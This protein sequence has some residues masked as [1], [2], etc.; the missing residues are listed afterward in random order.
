MAEALGLAASI[1]S[2]VSLLQDTVKA[3]HKLGQL[4]AQFQEANTE[5]LALRSELCDLTQTLGLVHILL[6]RLQNETSVNGIIKKEIQ[7]TTSEICKDVEEVK[8]V[9][10]DFQPKLDMHKNHKGRLKWMLKKGDIGSAMNR[11]IRR[12]Q[13]LHV[14]LSILH[15]NL[16]EAGTSG[17]QSWD[18]KFHLLNSRMKEMSEQV[19]MS[20][21]DSAA[22]VQHKIETSFADVEETIKVEVHRAAV[23][24]QEFCLPQ[25]QLESLALLVTDSL[26][27]D[28]P[29]LSQS[30]KQGYMHPL[31]EIPEQM[32]P[33]SSNDSSYEMRERRPNS[34]SVSSDKDYCSVFSRVLRHTS[35]KTFACIF[36]HLE[37]RRYTS[38]NLLLDSMGDDRTS[39]EVFKTEIGFHFAP[40]LRHFIKHSAIGGAVKFSAGEIALNIFVPRIVDSGDTIQ[41]PIWRAVQ[42]GHIATIKSALTQK[43]VQ[44]TDVTLGGQSLLATAANWGQI[45]VCKL[46]LQQGAATGINMVD[47]YHQ[48]APIHN[49]AE[50]LNNRAGRDIVRLFLTAGADPTLKSGLGHDAATWNLQ[51]SPCVSSIHPNDETIIR[52]LIRSDPSFDLHQRDE[53]GRTL[54]MQARGPPLCVY[55]DLL[56]LGVDATVTDNEGNNALHCYFSSFYDIFDHICHPLMLQGPDILTSLIQKGANPEQRNDTGQL[57]CEVYDE[58]AYER[59][60]PVSSIRLQLQAVIWSEALSRCGIEN[61]PHLFFLLP[62]QQSPL[63]LYLS[64]RPSIESQCRCPL[65]L[66]VHTVHSPPLNPFRFEDR[67][68]AVAKSWNPYSMELCPRRSDWLG[69]EDATEFVAL[70][71]RLLI[72][73]LEFRRA[74]N[75][76]YWNDGQSTN[77]YDVLA[78]SDIE[79]IRSEAASE[80]EW[81][82]AGEE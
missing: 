58:T 34:E 38:Q 57:P 78:E 24:S 52:L 16:L 53:E 23:S 14:K 45:E 11:I 21:R 63:D 32:E 77:L 4:I 60:H 15:T 18:D 75:G 71:I 27:R 80:E 8:D 64:D 73:E 68:I 3:C 56:K 25:S 40:W 13:A 2:M 61:T 26:L 10:E 46:L 33:V 55:D 79:Q 51:T 6:E 59:E 54:L 72:D 50:S 48:A 70:K 19:E 9:L 20:I 17:L 31:S 36:G 1:G 65:R 47:F 49:A 74:Q 69:L 22:K 41:A 42:L 81:F 82:S 43:L 62:L 76:Q 28:N 37:V 44:P 39:S 30:S 7:K 35:V 29:S 67:M 12:H 66:S 5:M